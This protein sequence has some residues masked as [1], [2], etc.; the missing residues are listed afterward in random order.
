MIYRPL[1]SGLLTR[2]Q[3]LSLLEVLVA[4]AV[5]LTALGGL[6]TLLNYATRRAH[7]VQMRSQ[8]TRLCQSKLAEVLSGAIPLTGQDGAAFDEDPD[9]QWSL[10][11]EQGSV[12]GLWNVSVKVSWGQAANGARQE[13]SLSQMILDPSII[14]STQDTV[15]IGGADQPTTPGTNPNTSPNNP[16]SQGSTVPNGSSPNIGQS[17]KPVGSGR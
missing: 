16:P 12:S 17:A 15:P 14:G 8:A 4:L 2:R 7:E 13:I 10:T 6:F 3:G 9:Y 11:A 1:P 5:F